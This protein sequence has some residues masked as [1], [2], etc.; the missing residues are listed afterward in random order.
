MK[1]LPILG[2]FNEDFKTTC[3]NDKNFKLFIAFCSFVWV[4]SSHLR[5]FHSYGDVSIT[6][7][8]LQILTYAQHSRPLS[9]EGSLACHTYCDTGHPSI[10]VI[11]KTR[12]THTCCQAFSSGAVTTCLYDLGLSQLGFEHSTFRFG[13]NALAHCA[14]TAGFF[15]CKSMFLR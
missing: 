1:L 10:M 5:I 11:S 13:A 7:E 14:T 4:L 3:L 2:S 9:S 15:H 12:D 6:R 8:G